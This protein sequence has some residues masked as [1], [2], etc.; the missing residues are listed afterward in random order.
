M[1]WPDQWQFR[2]SVTIRGTFEIPTL[3]FLKLNW[4]TE[5]QKFPFWLV[6]WGFR[7]LPEVQNCFCMTLDQ[8]CVCAMLC[9][10][11]QSCLTLL[12][13]HGLQPA[14]LLC[15]WGF[16]RQEYWSGCHA[17]LQGIFPIQVLNPGLALQGDSLPSEPLLR[18]IN[19]QTKSGSWSLR[20]FSLDFFSHGFLLPIDAA[21]TSSIR[22]NPSHEFSPY[23]SLF[24]EILPTPFSSELIKT[25]QKLNP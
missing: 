1:D 22:S 20:L 3:N 7:M 14:R 6:L 19:K 21:H 11:T 17:L 12:W 8:N 25:C 10:V 23:S 5:A 2:I 9:L 24:L 4:I 15:L 18:Q 13:P 16:S